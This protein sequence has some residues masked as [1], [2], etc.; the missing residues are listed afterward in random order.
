MNA[1]PVFF[2]A[3]NKKNTAHIRFVQAMLARNP[4]NTAVQKT[5]GLKERLTGESDTYVTT[6]TF[7][8]N[9]I[10]T[11]SYNSANTKGSS[12]ND[13]TGYFN[14]ISYDPYGYDTY[15]NINGAYAPQPCNVFADTVRNYT[16]DGSGISLTGYQYVTYSNNNITKII[17]FSGSD[18]T[19]TAA[20]YDGQNNILSLIVSSVL[21]GVADTSTKRIF[22][23]A[24]NKLLADSTYT[25]SP[26]T[27]QF[28][29]TYAYDVS[30]NLT[31]VNAY[32]YSNSTTI[33]SRK[34]INTYT[35]SD[36]LKTS[37]EDD[38]D[39]SNNQWSTAS[40]DSFGYSGGVNF[41]TFEKSTAF[42]NGVP[43]ANT[44]QLHVSAAGLVDSVY[45]VVD[46][47]S[48]VNQT[49]IKYIVQYDSYNNPV[50]AKGYYGNGTAFSS[51]PFYVA[52]YTYET[53]NATAVPA[54]T[55]ASTITVYPNPANDMVSIS[56]IDA[57][58]ANTTIRI[59]NTMGQLLV[60]Q[61][62]DRKPVQTIDINR[63]SPGVYILIITN[64]SGK[65][66][67]SQKV[68]KQ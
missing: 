39:F 20:T 65:M 5:T 60:T 33:A 63:L 31:Q 19:T 18:T 49:P 34:Y 68:I 52:R 1:Q 17:S 53:Y 54:V 36:Q 13:A 11:Y 29:N 24:H 15:G 59:V 7:N 51:I 23:Y 32:D 67:H 38:M 64:D 21:N 10:T 12:F 42:E 43:Q 61:S 41:Y 14:G 22:V 44:L 40:I 25:N 47:G 58:A 26:L 16:N 55:T 30:S 62:T 57:S 3:H 28:V 6:N 50:I 48:V 9:P 8:F 27:V 56:G 66:L 37:E 46:T 45:G 35:T 2:A 4:Q